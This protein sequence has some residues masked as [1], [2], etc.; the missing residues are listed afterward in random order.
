MFEIKISLLLGY[1]LF[2]WLQTDVFI[3][4][5]LVLQRFFLFSGDKLKI[6]EY[7]H[8]NFRGSYQS[9]L[10][11]NYPN[12]LTKLIS[13]PICLCFWLALPVFIILQSQGCL[14]IP[15]VTL[16]SYYILLFLSRKITS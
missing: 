14:I 11:H 7:I 12:F 9:Y 8:S 10:Y 1:L 15:Y 4:Y 5:Y 6:N 2:C 13:C 3:Q 16:V